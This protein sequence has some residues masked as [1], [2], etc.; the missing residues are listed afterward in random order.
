ME[1]CQ[2]EQAIDGEP[3][4]GCSRSQSLQTSQQGFKVPADL[5]RYESS[6]MPSGLPSPRAAEFTA[7]TRGLAMLRT[8]E[9]ISRGYQADSEWERG[10]RERSKQK[11]WREREQEAKIV[12]RQREVAREY[13]AALQ[14]LEDSK[15]VKALGIA[16]P[17]LLFGRKKLRKVVLQP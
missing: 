4:V 8:A 13:E 7:R 11:E 17:Q 9:G 15:L 3:T 12:A 14:E 5:L 2:N 16:S 1:R 10:L 6:I